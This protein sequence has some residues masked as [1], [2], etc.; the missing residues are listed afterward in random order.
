MV[1]STAWL[2]KLGRLDGDDR[3]SMK[4]RP[5]M[6]YLK[7]EQLVLRARTDVPS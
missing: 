7:L 2:S 1:S 3:A 5:F 4:S 6:Y